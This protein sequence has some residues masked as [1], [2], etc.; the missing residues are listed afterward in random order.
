LQISA[1]RVEVTAGGGISI[2]AVGNTASPGFSFAKS[3]LA[4]KPRQSDTAVEKN[5]SNTLNKLAGKLGGRSV[6][7]GKR[8]G[9]ESS[10]AEVSPIA[11]EQATTVVASDVYIR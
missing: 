6:G 7:V 5:S 9:E 8:F 10:L 2:E 11:F 4:P 3:G 1:Q